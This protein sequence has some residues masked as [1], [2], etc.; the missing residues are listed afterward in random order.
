MW[1]T[2]NSHV[3]LDY[4]RC[5]SQIAVTNEMNSKRQVITSLLIGGASDEVTCGS[6]M[7]ERTGARASY[8]YTSYTQQLLNKLN[9]TNVYK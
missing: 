3:Y 5:D 8:T 6:K 1:E 2:D 9:I 7:N 4:V